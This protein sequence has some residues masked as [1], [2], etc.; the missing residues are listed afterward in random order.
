M[1]YA[2]KVGLASAFGYTDSASATTFAFDFSSNSPNGGSFRTSTG[3]VNNSYSA[4]LGCILSNADHLVPLKFMPSCRIQLT[5][6]TLANAYRV[7]TTNPITNYSI[8]NFELCYDIIEFSPMVDQAITQLGQ[9]KITIRSQSFLSSGTSLGASTL[10]NIELV[11]NQRLASIKSLFAH[12]SPNVSASTLFDS[13]DLTSNNGDY[14]FFV[15]GIPYPPRPI[16]TVLNKA[17]ALMELSAAFGPAHDLITSNFAINPTEFGYTITS[18]PAAG[19]NGTTSQLGKFYIGTNC[20][21]LSTNGALLTGISSQGSPISI[22]LNI[23]TST[24]ANGAC[25]VQ[26]ICLYDALLQIDIP[27]RT[28]VVLQ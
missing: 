21:K 2:Q 16:S 9:G 13:V 17:G 12:L 4:P 14:Q 3:A 10:G 24:G 26:L 15:S 27:S 18:V 19:T 6:E 8:S 22:R 20:E 11:Y 23:G 5:T 7:G 25:V 1:N 28:L